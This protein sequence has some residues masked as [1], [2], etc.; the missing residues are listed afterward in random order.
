MATYS[1]ETYTCARQV[2]ATSSNWLA[3][4]T[5]LYR[6]TESHSSV[7]ELLL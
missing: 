4:L 3:T 5:V 2:I 6:Q 1:I 7:L